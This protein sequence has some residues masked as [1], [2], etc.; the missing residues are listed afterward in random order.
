MILIDSIGGN[1]HEEFIRA[2]YC[3]LINQECESNILEDLRTQLENK[4]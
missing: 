2:L 1:F 3:V 4:E